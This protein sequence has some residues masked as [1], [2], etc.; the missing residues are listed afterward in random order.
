MKHFSPLNLLYNALIIFVVAAVF[1]GATPMV[2]CA[3]VAAGAITGTA[4]SFVPK[5]LAFMAIQKEIWLNH[6]E[7]EIFKDNTFLKDSFKANDF[8]VGGRAVHV[9]QS[10]GSGNVVKNRATLPATVRKRNDTDVIYLLDEYTSDPVL[11]PNIDTMELS[12]DKRSSVLG[13]DQDKLKQT[14]AEETIYNWLNSPAYTGYGA[15]SLPSTQVLETTGANDGVPAAS[16]ATGTRKRATIKDLQRMATKFRTENRWFEGQM[17]A[18]LTPQDLEDMFPADST[19]TATYMQSVTEQE[20]RN[21][22]MYKAQGWNIKSRSSVTRLNDAGTILTP[23]AVGSATDDAASLFWYKN[24]VE[25]AMGD[26]VFFDDL[27]NPVYYGDVYSFLVRAGGRARRADY[28]GLALLKQ[29]KT[30]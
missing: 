15:T 22:I 27:G 28:K 4:M 19:T 5:G 6:I 3:S 7:E 10:G 18:L 16:G 2:A 29:A 24:A 23:E 30:A 14:V 11:I 12:Y 17:T 1:F 9:P 25:F 26:I 13:E 21:G 20:R 8:V